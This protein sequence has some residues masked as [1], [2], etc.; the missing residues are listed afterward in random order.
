MLVF[1]SNS[2][3]VVWG[4]TASVDVKIDALSDIVDDTWVLED[5][6]VGA[7]EIT[8]I[9]QCFGDIS[10]IYAL[11]NN[12][13]QCAMTLSF[14]VLIGRKECKTGSSLDAVQKGIDAYKSA[15][16]S[17]HTDPVNVT[18]GSFSKMGWITGIE[19]G[20]M[21][22]LKGICHGT[23]SLIMELDS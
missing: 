6:H 14:V 17:Q 15:R 20:Q 8:D 2:E 13:A 21:E 23:I 10:F 11:G 16:I 19:I 1:S 4:P 5:M 12:Q 7:H 9:R 3:V 22:P 18:V